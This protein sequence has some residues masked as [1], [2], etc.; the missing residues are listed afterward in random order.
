[1][2]VEESCLGKGL[3]TLTNCGG[4]PSKIKFLAVMRGT[5]NHGAES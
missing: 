4:N 2:N 1:M 5:N 3:F